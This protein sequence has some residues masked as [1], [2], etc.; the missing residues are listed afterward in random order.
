MRARGL[1]LIKGGPVIASQSI[2]WQQVCIAG[3]AKP[4][5][6]IIEPFLSQASGQVL[7]GRH[8]HLALQYP[9]HLL[10]QRPLG[11]STDC[12]RYPADAGMLANPI[13]MPAIIHKGC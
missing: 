6:S 11:A 7:T 3:Y 9:R 10:Q 8:Q 4:L 1:A 12:A 5:I 13:Q 2:S